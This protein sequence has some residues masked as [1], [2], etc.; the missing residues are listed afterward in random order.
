MDFCTIANFFDLI[1]PHMT[2]PIVD[3]I[4]EARAR[5]ATLVSTGSDMAV[6]LTEA[7]AESA[8]NAP[9]A[10]RNAVASIREA[11][12]GQLEDDAQV[13]VT[14]MRQG[15]S[16]PTINISYVDPPKTQCVYHRSSLANKIPKLVL[17]NDCQ[18]TVD[19]QKVGRADDPM[20]R[21]ACADYRKD[22]GY[23]DTILTT[24][25]LAD[26]HTLEGCYKSAIVSVR[27]QHKL[28]YYSSSKLLASHRLVPKPD[29]SL[30]SASQNHLTALAINS[31]GYLIDKIYVADVTV[32]DTVSTGT[33]DV[34]VRY[35][36]VPFSHFKQMVPS[37]SEK[38]ISNRERMRLEHETKREALRLMHQTITSGADDST[39]DKV[40]RN[41][42]DILTPAPR[43]REWTPAEIA[44]RQRARDLQQEE[45]E[46]EKKKFALSVREVALKEARQFPTRGPLL[47]DAD[48]RPPVFTKITRDVLI[49][50]FRS[51]C[52]VIDYRASVVVMKAWPVFARWVRE[53]HRMEPQHPELKKGKF[54]DELRKWGQNI[55]PG[56]RFHATGVRSDTAKEGGG[57]QAGI[58]GVRLR[59]GSEPLVDSQA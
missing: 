55:M 33:W 44:D 27:T 31:F 5:T 48:G 36:E 28:E 4:R 46:L 18:L 21:R 1:L 15:T 32:V 13:P 52:C 42:Y 58:K 38:E 34:Y 6:A 30:A 49:Q 57:G 10:I 24:K 12:E 14:V 3:C 11:T 22:Y 25:T 53:S 41:F 37:S 29:E 51:D 16:R 9:E 8:R 47:L 39:V 56:V 23:F 17:P 54:I 59:D 50:F 7:N 20:I 26:S 45:L 35:N 40:A 19:V 2:G 43:P